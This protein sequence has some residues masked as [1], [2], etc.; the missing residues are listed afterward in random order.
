MTYGARFGRDN[1]FYCF[2]LGFSG[3]AKL[4]MEIAEYMASVKEPGVFVLDYVPNCTA[5]MIDADAEKFQTV[6]DVITY[7][8][9]NK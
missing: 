3:N 7:L 4:D 2:N 5:D 9:N 6:G 8:E 1:G